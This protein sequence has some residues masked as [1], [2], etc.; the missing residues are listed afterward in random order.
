MEIIS[1]FEVVPEDFWGGRLDL[2][3]F[4]DKFV[5]VLEYGVNYCLI[6]LSHLF[7]FELLMFWFFVNCFFV[8]SYYL[9]VIVFIMIVSYRHNDPVQPL[10]NC[11]KALL[12][13]FLP[14]E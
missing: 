7:K 12:H 8:H 10:K 4:R 3:E 1:K 9:S 14:V 6:T 13:L 11:C 2:Q 5:Y